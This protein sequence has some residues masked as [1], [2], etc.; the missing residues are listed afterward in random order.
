V[1]AN[2]FRFTPKQ[3]KFTLGHEFG[4]FVANKRHGWSDG[5]GGNAI[6]MGVKF[7]Y[8]RHGFEGYLGNAGQ[9]TRCPLRASRSENF[10]SVGS[11]PKQNP[12]PGPCRK[13]IQQHFEATL[14][15]RSFRTED[16]I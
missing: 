16:R 12:I 15:V 14:I 3:R 1:A 6:P 2:N 10:A 13:D 4:L 9:Y 11:L 5:S 8:D 7:G